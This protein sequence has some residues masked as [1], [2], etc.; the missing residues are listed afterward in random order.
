MI[1]WVLDLEIQGLGYLLWKRSFIFCYG[2]QTITELIKA[3]HCFVVR[4]GMLLEIDNNLRDL[5]R[6]KG[7]GDEVR[8]GCMGM[9][10]EH[11][12]LIHVSSA[13]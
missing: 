6:L 13:Y 4:F 8:I 10:F 9:K 1:V 7:E 11:V 5:N 3:M 12:G 2:L